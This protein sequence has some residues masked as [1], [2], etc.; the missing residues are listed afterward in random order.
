MRALFQA[1]RPRKQSHLLEGSR[2]GLAS[3]PQGPRRPNPASG[4]QVPALHRGRTD[5][6]RERR[7]GAG[8]LG[9][10]AMRKAGALLPAASPS[11]SSLLLPKAG[12]LLPAAGGQPGH[13]GDVRH[14]A[15]AP[16]RHRQGRA[17]GAAAG[18]ILSPETMDTRGLFVA[19]THHNPWLLSPMVAITH[20]LL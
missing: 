17:K 10:R 7:T 5:A 4:R 20:Q 19:I 18:L 8:R 2:G 16:S 1:L 15:Q 3:L 6:R 9:R 13:E 11:P 12:A 14:P